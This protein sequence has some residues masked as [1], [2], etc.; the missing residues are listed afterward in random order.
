MGA[1]DRE[2]SLKE[3][4]ESTGIPAQR[5]VWTGKKKPVAYYTFLRLLQDTP[6]SADDRPEET[7]EMWRITLIHKGDFEAQLN[8]AL[9][10]LENAGYYINSVD[11]ENYETDTGYWIVPITVEWIKE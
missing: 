6:L 3:I 7:R 10:V 1:G 8:K 9:K 5:A 4:L 11:P 2:M